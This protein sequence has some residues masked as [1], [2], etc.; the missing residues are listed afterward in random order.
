MVA[1][2]GTAQAQDLL[3]KPGDWQASASDQ[4]KAEL[5][6]HEAA[7]AICLDYDF[8]GVSGYAVLRRALPILW[9]AHWRLD[10][11]LNGVGGRN[12]VQ[13]KFVDASGD[14]VWWINQPDEQLPGY[15]APRSW[16]PRH[17]SFAW[18]PTNDRT[19]RRTAF[20]EWVI[21]AGRDGGKGSACLGKLA[22]QPAAAPP[23]VWPAP[24]AR[25]TGPDSLQWDLGGL[26]EF[27]GLLLHWPQAEGLGYVLEQSPDGKHWLDLRNVVGG[28]GGMAALFLPER[29]ARH[30]RIR[31]NAAQGQLLKDLRLELRDPE[32]W[33]N[34]NAML[35]EQ[36]KRMPRGQMPRAFLG[37]Q[38]Y[39]ALVG[40]DGGGDRSGLINEDGEI[41]LG[42]GAPSVAPQVELADGSLLTWADVKISH[43]LPDGHLPLPQVHWRHPKLE[44]DIQAGAD[45][46]AASPQLL[47]RYSL[48]NPTDQTQRYTLRLLLRPWQVNP[49]Q[50]FL[51]TQGGTSPIDKLV[52]LD[53]RLLI[54]PGHH[55]LQPQTMPSLVRVATGDDG[56]QTPSRP[57]S[58]FMHSFLVD[59]EQQASARLD[60]PLTLAPGASAS[61][62]WAAPLGS[63]ER[64]TGDVPTRLRQAEAD[65]RERLSGVQFEGPPAMQPV[66]ASLRMA[67]A[68]ILMSRQ[69]PALRPG[70]RSYAR[71]WIRDGAMMVAGLT[72]LGELQVAREFVDW[73]A[74]QVF[75]NGKVP[76]CIDQRGADPVVENDSHGQFIYSV[77]EVWRHSGD[78]AWLRSH[79]PRVQQVMVWMEAQRQKERGPKQPAHLFGLMPPSISHEGYSDKPAYS[80]WDNFWTLRGYKDAVQ[81]AEALQAPAELKTWTAQRDEFAQ[82]L[83]ASLRAS[84]KL[85]GRDHL[86]GAAD[87][88]DFDPTSTTIALNPVQ[89]Q[90]PPELLAATFERYWQESVQRAAGTREWKDYTP[91]ELRSVGAFVQLGQRERAHELLDFFFRD[92][93]PAGWKQWAEVVLPAYREPRFLGDMPHA[94]VASDYLRSALDFFAIERE[95]P[96]TLLLGAGLRA[97][98]L[99]TGDIAV[100]GLATARGPVDYALRRQA[101]GGW[102]LQLRQSP[103]AALSW[104]EEL[105]LPRARH[106][107]RDL[108]WQGRELPLPPAPA[109]VELLP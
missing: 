51:S 11:E 20:V 108:S 16:K 47:A 37:E 24:R 2:L 25:R 77:A 30:L 90:L 80:N 5:R 66:I 83:D 101:S 102:Q 60:F 44:L 75:A 93:R 34:R 79:W 43:S 89:A 50:Q 59:N 86:L 4:V 67:Q 38:N 58:A 31:M 68:H 54:G 17:L 97:G 73:F 55:R 81:I 84:S 95:A 74:P 98:W 87:R 62:A 32:Q 52:W 46:P 56:L 7:G 76:C 91:Y 1:L 42:R 103:P 22:L 99:Q 70:T 72:R 23:A 78:D 49:P 64:P 105:P 94:W 18:G 3:G 8:N 65:W 36:A 40:V 9:P 45:G 41:E 63:E 35:A 107:G 57:L 19:L 96:Q 106:A 28:R 26:R 10:A 92:Q 109:T 14:N 29:E 61:I 27:N 15:Y 88:G 13:L 33:P 85:H 39:W 21:A 69:G 6:Y 12:D 82:E 100:K 53:D 71:T 48:R 104:P